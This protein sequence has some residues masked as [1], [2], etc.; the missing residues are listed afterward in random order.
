MTDAETART[1]APLSLRRNIV[2]A[3]VG[4]GWYAATQFII[5]VLIAR[6]GTQTDLGAFTLASAIVT[7]LF[8]LAT[9]GARDVLTV[10]DLDRFSRADYL[11]LRVVGG[12]LAVALSLLIAWAVYGERG[13]LIFGAVAGL[14]MVRFFGAQASLNHAMFQRAERLDFVAASILIRATAGLVAFAFVFW[15]TRNLPY[16]LLAEAVFW[17]LSYLVVDTQLLRRLDVSMPLSALHE[18]KPRQVLALALWVLPVGLALWLLRASLSVPPIV[19]EQSAGLAAVGLFGALAYIH[20]ALSMLANAVTSAAAARMRRLARTGRMIEFRALAKR[21]AFVSAVVGAVLVGLAL[22]LGAPFL[23][24]VFGPDYAAPLLLAV[25]VAASSLYLTAS[26]L[27]TA[28]TALQAFRWRI[29][30]SGASF[31]AGSVAALAL[32]PSYAEMGAALALFAAAAAYLASSGVAF[33][34]LTGD[35]HSGSHDA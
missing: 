2:F 28:V 19:L 26:P 14:A 10:D 27:V 22:A 5:I 15:M 3:M 18:T 16:A 32:I 35:R 4:R 11:G 33:V 6:L 1:T 31:V 23:R 8:F 34:Y 13:W 30:M 9:M 7:P 24:L 20:T 17:A 25:I 12:V 29:V 21:I